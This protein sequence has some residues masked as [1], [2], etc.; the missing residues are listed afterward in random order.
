[1][2]NSSG[3]TTVEVII[4]AV[5]LV[6]VSV[7]L[8]GLYSNNFGWIVGAGFRTDAVDKAKTAIDAKIAAGA[9]E[10]ADDALIIVFQGAPNVT[11]EGQFVDATGAAGP[12]GSTTVTLNTFIPK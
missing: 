1:M 10:A 11:V 7:A 3:L 5:I 12:N 6:I 2:R 8:L 9:D 4:A